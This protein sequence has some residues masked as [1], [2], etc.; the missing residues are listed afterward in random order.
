MKAK[1]EI[2]ALTI[3]QHLVASAL[4]P[5]LA[6][7]HT[8]FLHSILICVPS[9][10]QKRAGLPPSLSSDS[11]SASDGNYSSDA[12]EEHK[13]GAW[14]LRQIVS[15]DG[16]S[17]MLGEVFFASFDQRSE[18]AAGESACTALVAVIADWLHQHPGQMPTKA[19]FNQLIQEGS[20]E[21]RALCEMDEFKE[22]FK[23]RHFDLETVLGA[24]IKPLKVDHFH[25]FVGFFKPP[26]V[27]MSHEMLAGSMS[28]DEIWSELAK[29][30][31]GVYIVSWNDHFFILKVDEDRCYIIDTLGERLVEGCSRA[32]MLRFDGGC[33]CKQVVETK[34]EIRRE[35]EEK[36]AAAQVEK[37]RVAGP[38]KKQKP[39]PYAGGLARTASG[40]PK[41]SEKE[42]SPRGA[43][44]GRTLSMSTLGALLGRTSSGSFGAG[45]RS[46]EKAALVAKEDL[47]GKVLETNG[48][49]PEGKD[50]Q[51]LPEPVS[52]GEKAGAVED[53]EKVEEC[54]LG[55]GMCKGRHFVRDFLA[56]VPLR[57]LAEDLRAK[58]AVP[59]HQRLQIEFNY[60][61]LLDLFNEKDVK[62]L[63]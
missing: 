3:E 33:C 24:R 37:E 44:L 20:R 15:R 4:K 51:E 14:Q 18:S 36:A 42:D 7:R 8:S 1:P 17:R 47:K 25:S 34:A 63:G 48:A 2:L 22:S 9:R 40:V 58:R 52:E 55:R 62:K 13:V 56:A 45:S 39:S 19:A 50:G 23:D 30:G 31:E 60:T 46:A 53:A 61:Q 12:E 16:S 29:A 21:W 54:G 43:G 27:E 57:A 28:F 49:V 11:L 6:T 41:S 35:E 5:S 26:E 32:F 59:V 38:K 10:L